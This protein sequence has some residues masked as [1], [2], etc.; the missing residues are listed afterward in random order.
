LQRAHARIALLQDE[1]QEYYWDFTVTSDLLELR[2]IA[3]VAGMIIDCALQRPESRGLHYN[4]D[5]P[6]ADPDY[7]QKDSVLRRERQGEVKAG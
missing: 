5:Y 1:I 2:N 7:S 4:L 6:S 3:T